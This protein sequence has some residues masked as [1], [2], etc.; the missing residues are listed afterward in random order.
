MVGSPGW[1]SSARGAIALFALGMIGVIA[2]AMYSVPTLREIPELS[3]LSYPILA[4]L[5]AVNSTLILI[6]FVGLGTVT[7]PRIGL[8]SHVF[9]WA[10][11]G[12]TDWSKLTRVGFTESD[13]N[14]NHQWM[15]TS[16][17]VR[18]IPVG[19]TRSR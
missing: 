10:T 13:G 7:A 4:V 17:N 5:A 15:M 2:L 1:K 12:P 3:M 6:V 11:G 9:T 19:I 16:N 18:V 8:N 14:N